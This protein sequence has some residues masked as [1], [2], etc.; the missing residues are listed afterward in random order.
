MDWNAGI[1]D[2][3]IIA[4]LIKCV[5]KSIQYTTRLNKSNPE[6]IMGFDVVNGTIVVVDVI[7]VSVVATG[8]SVTV[9]FCW[10]SGVS[11][12]TVSVNWNLIEN[13]PEILVLKYSFYEMRKY[14]NKKTWI[15]LLGVVLFDK[16]IGSKWFSKISNSF[17][18]FD[19][20]FKAL[21]ITLSN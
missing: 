1:W 3:I 15:K 13:V 8:L 12:S 9:S 18:G 6:L 4:V 10:H 17:I 19:Y 7:G 21:N 16:K 20:T 11:F 5:I 2:K 14:G